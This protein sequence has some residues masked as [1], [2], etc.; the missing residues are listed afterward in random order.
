VDTKSGTHFQCRSQT[1]LNTWLLFPMCLSSNGTI[2]SCFLHL[3]DYL[4]YEKINFLP[5]GKNYF[6]VIRCSTWLRGIGLAAF[7]DYYE[8][9]QSGPTTT[10]LNPC[11]SMVI[12]LIQVFRV[13]P[14]ALCS[15][16]PTTIAEGC[17]S[18]GHGMA[19]RTSYFW[20]RLCL[21]STGDRLGS[22]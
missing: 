22:N 8:V 12:D 4:G 9:V 3:Y 14:L 18:C 20:W 7:C 19:C 21:T 16:P 6:E 17:I 11:C 2:N 10:P 15:K 5:L 1:I 13:R